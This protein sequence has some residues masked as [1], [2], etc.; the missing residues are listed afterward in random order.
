MALIDTVF[1]AL[2]PPI[3][4]PYCNELFH[5]G[6]CAVVSQVNSGKVIEQPPQGRLRRAWSRIAVKPLVGPK[7]V[8]EWASRQCPYCKELLPYDFEQVDDNLTIA[9]VGDSFSGK[10]HYIATMIDQLRRGQVSNSLGIYQLTASNQKIEERYQREYYEPLFKDK[11]KIPTTIQTFNPIDEPLIFKLTVSGATKK[12]F[13]LLIYD[14]SGE[15]IATL[16]NFVQYKR[17]ILN[18]KAIIFIADPWAMPGFTDHLA[19]HLRPEPGYVTG[20]LT[21]DVLQKVVEAFRRNIGDPGRAKFP[22]PVAITLSKSDLIEYLIAMNNERYKLLYDPIY[23]SALDKSEREAVDANVC[24]LLDEIKEHSLLQAAEDFEKVSFFAISATGTSANS[25][26][27]YSDVK[28]H[29]TLEPL[30]W[31]L[32]ELHIVD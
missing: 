16:L 12:Q 22:L 18:A 10:S 31:V 21:S 3:R 24:A 30:F 15:D 17:H 4:C 7:Y 20:R 13:N 14:A 9:V 5:L 29:R 2:F 27:I 26:G 28:P 6:E 32:R 19:H 23:P 8:G 1:D 11:Q 25:N